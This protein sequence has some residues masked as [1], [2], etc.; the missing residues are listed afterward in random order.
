MKP[1]KRFFAISAFICVHL[2]LI[3]LVPARAAERPNILFI[4]A[5]DLGA[6]DLG[7]YGCKDIRTP[8]IDRLARQGVRFTQFYSNGPD[9]T[10]TRTGF[11]TGRYQHRVGGLECA[12]GVGN[13]GRY[14]D[15]IRLQKQHDLGLPPED[16]VLPRALKDAGYATAICGKWHLGY[17]DKFAPN[18]HGFD[19]AVYCQGGGMD[20]FHHV[21]AQAPTETVLRLDGRPLRR[22]GYFTD[23]VAED[24]VQWLAANRGKP[25]FL[26]VPFTAPHAPFQG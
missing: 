7:C 22:P 23:L 16:S 9:C 8:N 13:V 17:E 2:W 10:P 21:E 1:L 6:A 19:H 11:L 4:L 26:Y 12:L 25:F 18:R 20:Y 5:D 15:A 24:A 14:D 3:P